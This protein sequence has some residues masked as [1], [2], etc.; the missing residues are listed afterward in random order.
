MQL[1]NTDGEEVR[2]PNKQLLLSSI[3]TK[4]STLLGKLQTSFAVCASD[5]S[6]IRN[7]FKYFLNN[8]L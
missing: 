1:F 5:I 6:E 4:N 7:Q 8:K 3:N 2:I